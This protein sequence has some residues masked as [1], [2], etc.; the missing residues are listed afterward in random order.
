MAHVDAPLILTAC[1]TWKLRG[2]TCAPHLGCVGR[3]PALSLG[4]SLPVC[5]TCYVRRCRAE[6]CVMFCAEVLPAGLSV[7]CCGAGI[8]AQALP[9]PAIKCSETFQKHRGAATQLRLA[10]A[11]RLRLFIHQPSHT[12]TLSAPPATKATTRTQPL[13]SVHGCMPGPGSCP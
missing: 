10:E 3:R 5:K 9:V 11:K 6:S 2:A 1:F 7:V 8:R 13:L 12:V 4:F